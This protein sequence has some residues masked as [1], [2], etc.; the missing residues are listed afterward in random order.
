MITVEGQIRLARRV[1]RRVTDATLAVYGSVALVLGIE[2]LV[3]ERGVGLMLTAIGLVGIRLLLR[4][5]ERRT[6]R[7]R[8]NSSNG[9]VSCE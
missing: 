7:E 2:V 8:V 6:V 9:E 1:L 4:R 5:D 3:R